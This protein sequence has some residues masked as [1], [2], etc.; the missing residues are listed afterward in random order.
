MNK[1]FPFL[2]VAVALCVV[3]LFVV[4]STFFDQPPQGDI[5]ALDPFVFNNRPGTVA[6]GTPVSVPGG[7]NPVVGSSQIGTLTVQQLLDDPDT[8]AD[9]Y[10]DGLYYLGN[11]FPAFEGPTTTA[12]AYVIVFDAAGQTFNI[13][14]LQEPIGQSR[15]QAEDFMMKKFGLTPEQLCNLNYTVTVPEDVNQTYTSTNLKF[16]VCNDAVFLP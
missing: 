12:P 5:N 9:P 2:A 4:G 16:G 10:N 11:R 15:T 6:S 3:L 8:H 7:S 13:S 1:I 14:L